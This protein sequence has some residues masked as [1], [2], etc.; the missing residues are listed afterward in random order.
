VRVSRILFDPSGWFG[1]LQ[2]RALQPYPNLLAQRIIALNYPALRDCHSSYR[3]QLEK[4]ATRGDVISLNHRASAFLASVFDILF[5]LN[6][7]AHPGEK[8]LLD[9]AQQLCPLRPPEL[10][11]DITALLQTAA[12]NPYG[13]VA[14]V[15]R[16]VD[17]LKALIDAH[18]SG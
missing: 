5:A 1:R 4:A 6:K 13:V 12:T 17:S 7:V 2:H 16:L 3:Q 10:R 15:D 18:P 11:E 14:A 9:L 8:R